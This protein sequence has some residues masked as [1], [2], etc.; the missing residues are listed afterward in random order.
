MSICRCSTHD[1]T[2]D[3]DYHEECPGCKEKY[4]DLKEKEVEISCFINNAKEG[5]PEYEYELVY[6]ILEDKLTEIKR[7]I[8]DMQDSMFS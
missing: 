4:L 7:D 8:K 1:E 3:S 6:K 2:W 5:M